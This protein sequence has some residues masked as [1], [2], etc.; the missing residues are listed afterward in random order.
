MMEAIDPFVN[1]LPLRFQTEE[2]V[3][4]ESLLKETRSK[5]LSA[6][7]NLKVPFQVPLNE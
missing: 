2:G 6:L 5:L 3:M 4:F 1:L 7:A